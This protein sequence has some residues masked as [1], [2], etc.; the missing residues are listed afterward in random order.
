MRVAGIVLAALL[1]AACPPR[2]GRVVYAQPYTVPATPV[3]GPADPPPATAEEAALAGHLAA[4]EKKKASV[5]SLRAGV[6]LKRTDAVFKKDTSFT[7]AVLLK[8]PNFA[9]LRLENAGDPTK[10]GYEAY[11]CD[12]KAI[13]AYN[14][15][16]KTITEVA[17]PPQWPFRWLGA[18]TNPVLALLTGVTTPALKERF[19]IRLFKAD[20][21]YIYL[22]FKP[23]RDEDGREFRHLRLAL[24][25]PGEATAKLAYLPA[26]VYILK[27]GGDAEVWTFTDPQVDA[28]DIDEQAFQFVPLTGWKVQKAPRVPA[29]LERWR[30]GQR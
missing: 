15:G 30:P 19:D 20:A 12:G 7:G 16:Q 26:Q 22:D 6:A 11:R 18:G 4:W 9:A 8:K 23:R 1:I 13:Y 3:G 2:R 10:A 17:L 14:G 29:E 27:P 24:F 25:G 28:P 21:H 5:T